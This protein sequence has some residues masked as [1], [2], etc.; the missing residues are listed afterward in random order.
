MEAIVVRPGVL[1]PAS[2]IRFHAARSSGPGGQN[3]NKVSSKVEL[4]VD[5]EEI[6]GLSSEQRHRLRAQSRPYQ[7]AD[8]ALLVT[9]QRTR[10]QQDNL[11]DARDKI[12]A[13]VER[14]LHAP[15]RRIATKPSRAAKARRVEQKR[16]T[17]EKKRD[18]RTREG[19]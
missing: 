5:L 9:S 3:V 6:V 14:A 2:A 4:R 7:D 18:R 11:E 1:V 12:R 15:K 17:S 19:D 8:G 16:R 10:S 13:L